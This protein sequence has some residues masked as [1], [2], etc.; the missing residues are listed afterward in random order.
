MFSISL[1]DIV[2]FVI[3]FIWNITVKVFMAI[4]PI[5]TYSSVYLYLMFFFSLKPSPEIHWK[6]ATDLYHMCI[7]IYTYLYVIDYQ[8]CYYITRQHCMHE[9]IIQ[10]WCIGRK[11]YFVNIIIMHNIIINI[12]I[13]IG[14]TLLIK[15]NCTYTGYYNI[16]WSSSNILYSYIINHI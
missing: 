6:H 4:P 3:F 13:I 14:S 7:Y 11:Y 5:Y 8:F 10:L 12:I 2:Y 1:H 9:N 16:I 15:I